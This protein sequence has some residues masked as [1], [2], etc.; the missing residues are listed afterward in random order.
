MR[1]CVRAVGLI[2]IDP[3]FEGRVSSTGV[4]L[5][6]RRHRT[7]L[8]E[9]KSSGTCRRTAHRTRSQHGGLGLL[10]YCPCYRWCFNPI[11]SIVRTSLGRGTKGKLLQ[12]MAVGPWELRCL[13]CFGE[14]CVFVVFVVCI[15]GTGAVERTTT[16]S[17]KNQM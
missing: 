3:G 16:M 17:K 13:T 7:I 14:H 8:D 6:W 11:L 10:R 12:R 2:L 4:V 1:K 5:K 9:G 15:S